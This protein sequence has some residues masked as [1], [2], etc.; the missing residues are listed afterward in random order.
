MSR[1]ELDVAGSRPSEASPQTQ[2]SGRRLGHSLIGLTICRQTT[3]TLGIACLV[4]LSITGG[5]SQST[6]SL[7]AL[8]AF[9]TACALA[10]S[11]LIVRRI[12]EGPIVSQSRGHA[13]GFTYIGW[14]TSFAVVGGFLGVACQSWFRP[15]T[16]IAAGDEALPNGTAWLGHVFDSWVWSGS[17]LGGPGALQLQL[18]WA[19]VLRLVTALGSNEAIAQRLWLT[20]L[21]VGVG[22]SAVLLSWAIGLHPI[23]GLIAGVMFAFNPFTLS[24]GGGNVV[25]VFLATQIAIA[26]LASILFAVGRGRIRA[27]TGGLLLGATAPLLGFVFQTPPEL[28]VACLA[29]PVAACVAWWLWG[30]QAARR[31]LE[32]LAMGI[33]LLIGLSAYWIVPASLQIATAATGQLSSLDSWHFTEI[34]ATLANAFWLNTHWT[35]AYP[36]Y[37]SYATTYDRQPLTTLIYLVPAAIMSVLMIGKSN[38]GIG[39]RHSNEALAL[40]T[41]L[42]TAGLPIIFLSTGTQFPAGPIFTALY[43]LPFGWLLREPGRFLVVDAL[44]YSLLGAILLTHISVRRIPVSGKRRLAGPVLDR[45]RSVVP[46]PTRR[47][48][49]AGALF[50]GAVISSYPLLTGDVIPDQRGFSLPSAHVTFPG[51]WTDLASYLNRSSAKPGAVLVLPLDD[52]YQMPYAFGY[53][54]ADTFITNLLDRHV[55][56]P[57]PQGY[58]YGSPGLVSA[59]SL[60]ASY[61]RSRDWDAAAHVMSDLG[62]T[63]VLLRGDITTFPG[64]PIDVPQNYANLVEDSS[65]TI[66][67]R[68]GP[69]LLM[70]TTEPPQLGTR[71]TEGFWTV[72]FPSIDPQLLAYVPQGIH[73]I[74]HKPIDGVSAL[75]ITPG[76]VPLVD[77]GF[78][79]TGQLAAPAKDCAPS[80]SRASNVRSAVFTGDGPSGTSYLRL[81]SISGIA[82]V[83][84]QL[85]WKSG[86]LE[87]EMATRHITGDSPHI[88]LLEGQLGRCATAPDLSSSGSWSTYHTTIYPDPG[89]TSLTLYLTAGGGNS[90]SESDYATVRATPLNIQ[91]A[92]ASTSA[93]PSTLTIDD[94]TYSPNWVDPLGGEHV[95]VDGLFNGWITATQP[96]AIVTARYEP[97]RL[98]RAAYSLTYSALFIAL[99]ALTYRS[100]SVNVLR[101]RQSGRRAQGL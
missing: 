10:W 25:P 29:I 79:F 83:A 12:H 51:Y 5:K 28:G 44:I 56:L 33:P 84:Q 35:W 77:T 1:F 38:L 54:G 34:R 95:A 67:Q 58:F 27:L 69:L 92:P 42:L 9:G 57:V 4:A 30:A 26:V 40:A 90:L 50:L 18:P 32:T 45:L 52:F 15:S 61:L 17:N 87:V 64:R 63:Y 88:C 80:P 7:V 71:T 55:L 62:V 85:P 11:E 22:I 91:T 72:D 14:G 60:T 24:S 6:I 36:A 59:V 98:L 73:L 100:L 3:A 19:V 8:V 37:V 13:R 47:H 46:G 43:G 49:A 23:G 65:L 93:G 81:T 101:R 96:S 94:S 39:S 82:C 89:T 74:A 99:V 78:T 68:F 75:T 20:A 76:N 2:Q 41:P 48:V 21:F 53:Y 97:D 70:S 86:P 66:E 16:V 31:C